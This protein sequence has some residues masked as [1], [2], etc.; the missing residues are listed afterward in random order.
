[1]YT[2]ILLPEVLNPVWESPDRSSLVKENKVLYK[3]AN[4][5]T[6]GHIVFK[7]S[8]TYWYQVIFVVLLVEGDYL[9]PRSH[10]LPQPLHFLPLSTAFN[11]LL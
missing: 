10:P 9:L 7:G 4:Q 2:S 8:K 1:M 5:M 11:L 3:A 6:K